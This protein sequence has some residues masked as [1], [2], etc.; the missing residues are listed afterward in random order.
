MSSQAFTAMTPITVSATT[1]WLTDLIILILQ[2]FAHFTAGFMDGTMIVVRL[3]FRFFNWIIWACVN[4]S[5]YEKSFLK[6]ILANVDYQMDDM[7]KYQLE[8]AIQI[9]K[10]IFFAAV[11]YASV[12]TLRRDLILCYINGRRMTKQIKSQVLR[13]CVVDNVTQVLDSN[14]VLLGQMNYAITPEKAIPSSDRLPAERMSSLVECRNDE[15]MRVGYG[16]R[17]GLF[18]CTAT[19]VYDST[20]WIV[21]PYDNSRVFHVKDSQ[22]IQTA[23]DV[24][25]LKFKT[26]QMSF[27]GV[28]SARVSEPTRG[29][30]VH[31]PDVVIQCGKATSYKTA[32]TIEGEY[33]C[34]NY[35]MAFMHTASTYP[36][37]SG[38]PVMSRN[39]V[40]GV[41]LGAHGVKS[42]NVAAA[43]HTLFND[44]NEE[45]ALSTQAKMFIEYEDGPTNRKSRKTLEKP[46]WKQPEIQGKAWADYDSDE[47]INL[48]GVAP[49]KSS[50]TSDVEEVVVEDFRS[51]PMEVGASE[52]SVTTSSP[53]IVETSSMLTLDSVSMKGCSSLV[54]VTSEKESSTENPSITQ[55]LS[56]LKKL[57]QKS[58]I[59]PSRPRKQIQPESLLRS[60]TVEVQS[61][62]PGLAEKIPKRHRRKRSKHQPSQNGSK[63]SSTPSQTTS[64]VDLEEKLLN[65][66][67]EI[68]SIKS[69][70][71]QLQVASST[72]SAPPTKQC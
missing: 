49:V 40:V 13:L 12:Q 6:W 25:R 22:L 29:S 32:G 60:S 11:A 36:G 57:S 61:Q 64:T 42:L 19:H 3:I 5:V 18:I 34:P 55:C 45:S 65:L 4:T 72:P 56:K 33:K 7:D 26:M 16:F 39:K 69:L 27:F 41:H 44:L 47:E 52:R 9:W 67:S 31:I 66:T 38:A 24:T 48:E 30:M 43:I 50:S 53:P 59:I 35:P 70:L 21:N 46:S 1:Q 17:V 62:N 23:N 2:V 58:Q 68:S 8:R 20:T 54:A 71:S 15:G 63:Q 14:G 51:G 37:I 10:W 28:K